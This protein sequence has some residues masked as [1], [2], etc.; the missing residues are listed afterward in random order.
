MAGKFFKML[1]NVV[2]HKLCSKSQSMSNE[3]CSEWIKNLPDLLKDYSSDNIYIVNETGLFFKE[4]L[5]KTVG[6]K[7]E[8]CHRG[9]QS[10]EQVT[11]LLAANISMTEKLTLLMIDQKPKIF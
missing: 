3:L 4:L 5:N 10:K 2:F 6:F 1:Q 9:N 7:K 11:L 8:M